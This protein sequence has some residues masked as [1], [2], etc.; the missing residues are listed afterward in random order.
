MAFWNQ[1]SAK[2]DQ[3]TND[4]H[5]RRMSAD[6]WKCTIMR[7]LRFT[8]EEKAQTPTRPSLANCI[9]GAVRDESFASLDCCRLL[10]K[11]IG[12]SSYIWKEP[13]K[14]SSSERSNPYLP[15]MGSQS[16]CDLTMVLSSTVQN[17][18]NLLRNRDS[19]TSQVV[20]KWATT[21][22]NLL[23]EEKDPRST[24]LACSSLLR[25][26]WFENNAATPI[27]VGISDSK[28]DLQDPLV[29]LILATRPETVNKTT[30]RS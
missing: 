21:A 22:K 19:I 14:E 10:S 12:S 4:E 27:W 3:P 9:K 13:K 28:R 23:S 2:V 6:R 11:L 25:S 29:T 20:Q 30:T 7:S 15:G 1:V 26:C 18:H 17:P 5:P 8:Q 16:K 24:P